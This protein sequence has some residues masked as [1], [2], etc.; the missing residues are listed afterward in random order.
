LIPAFAAGRAQQIVYMLRTLEASRAIPAVP[1]HVDSPMAVDITE[2]FCDF[3]GEHRVDLSANLDDPCGL[4]GDHIKYHRTKGS[5]QAL[6]DAHGPRVIISSSGML[7][8]GRILHHLARRAGDPRNIIAM[9]GFQAVGTRGRDL[10]DGKR[11]IRFHGEEIPVRAQVTEI[12]GLSA[13]GDY[14][15]IMRWLTSIQRAPDLT[16][17][18]HGEPVPA[19]AMARRVESERGF[20]TALPNLGDEFEL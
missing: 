3:P 15:E 11:S 16:F 8:G 1:I 13:H 6:N 5:S 14:S 2:I 18:T 7:T 20:K 12:T 9:A 19:A 4:H 10:L 17:I